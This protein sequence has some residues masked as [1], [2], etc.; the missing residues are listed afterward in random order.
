MIGLFWAGAFFYVIGI[1]SYM[2]DPD[3]T[4][5]KDYHFLFYLIG[6]SLWTPHFFMQ[7]N[8]LFGFILLAMEI[9][10]ILFLYFDK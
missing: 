10:G 6:F 2:Y 8:I 3:L 1:V 7:G 9:V 4:E 5:L